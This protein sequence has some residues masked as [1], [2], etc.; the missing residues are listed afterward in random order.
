MTRK[1]KKAVYLW[2]VM[3]LLFLGSPSVWAQSKQEKKEQR[4]KDVKEWIDSKHFTIEVDRALPLRGRS[5]HLTSP[6]SLE[7]RGDSV[8]SYL[9]YFGRAY[10]VPYGG[11]NGMR[12][13]KPMTE[14]AVTYGKKGKTILLFDTKTDD[15]KYTFFIEIYPNGSA[16]I[17]VTPVNRQSISYYGEI[18]G[19]K[20]E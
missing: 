7:L 14:Y 3:F 13:E 9:P 11:G 10:N 18:T 1:K 5:V 4:E 12:F 16:T 15:D 17:Q 8:F 6:Y 20:E 2:S 19:P